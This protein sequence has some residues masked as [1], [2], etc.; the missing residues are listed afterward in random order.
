MKLSTELGDKRLGELKDSIEFQKKVTKSY[1]YDMVLVNEE[2]ELYN[3]V[4]RLKEENTTLKTSID[5]KEESNKE[6]LQRLSK[7]AELVRKYT[8]SITTTTSDKKQEKINKM[9]LVD[10]ELSNLMELL[11]GTRYDK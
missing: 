4:I 10:I 1:G 7:A 5:E 9:E 8:Y 6:L 2:E 11:D 3:E